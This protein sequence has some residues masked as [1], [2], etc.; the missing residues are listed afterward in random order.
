MSEVEGKL[1]RVTARKSQS[2]TRRDKLTS[3]RE[4]RKIVEIGQITQR[5][6]YG[7]SSEEEKEE[8]LHFQMWSITKER[9][10]EVTRHGPVG[11]YSF[12]GSAR[13][14]RVTLGQQL[15]LLEHRF[16]MAS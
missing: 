14:S 9:V 2:G 12:L 8:L 16:Q 1:S 6:E 11:K 15:S 3:S 7:G 10:A 5:A 4:A 13:P